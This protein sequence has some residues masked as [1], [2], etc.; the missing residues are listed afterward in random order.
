MGHVKEITRQQ[1]R[2]GRDLVRQLTPARNAR[3]KYGEELDFW[4]GELQNLAAWFEEGTTDW[5]GL[6]PPAPDQRITSSDIWSVNAVL[7]MHEIRPTY[8]E[9]LKLEKTAFEGKR[10][11]EVGCGPLVPLQ[12]FPGCER[13]AIDPL[14]DKYIEAGWPLYA[15]DAKVINAFGEHL[16]YPDAYFDAVI[17]VNSLD[18]VDDF[19]KVSSEMQR[20]LGPGGRLCFEVEYHEATV[21]EPLELNDSKVRD[22]FPALDLEKVAERTSLDLYE[23]LRQRFG[24][25]STKFKDLHSG[26]EVFTT[27]HGTRR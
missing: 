4:R 6:A 27:W 19:A 17:A 25:A 14:I 5:W 9:E 15:Y 8:F 7:T 10:V 26:H 18:H 3:T 20:V 21:T 16:P 12:Q 13:H 23:A 22:A 2:H 24:L 1:L 11:L